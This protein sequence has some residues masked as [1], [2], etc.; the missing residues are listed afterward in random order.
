MLRLFILLALTTALVCGAQCRK[1][2]VTEE[3]GAT[4]TGELCKV[5]IKPTYGSPYFK[6]V[7][8]GEWAFNNENNLLYMKGRYDKKGDYSS[9]EGD[10]IWYNED[11]VAFVKVL[12]VN[13]RPKKLFVLDEFTKKI[14]AS[15]GSYPIKRSDRWK[16]KRFFSKAIS[17]LLGAP[18]PIT[19]NS[20][21][22]L[23]WQLAES[24]LRATGKFS[25]EFS[26]GAICE[27]NTRAL[28][29]MIYLAYL[30]N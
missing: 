3:N 13:D 23:T 26:G 5:K 7:K 4:G 2:S 24:R 16:Y 21:A 29:I 19:K 11:G 12:Y 17:L 22:G 28:N 14:I 6:E 25:R 15:L 1:S 8:S 30:I 20:T 10:W 18:P 9:K 27:I